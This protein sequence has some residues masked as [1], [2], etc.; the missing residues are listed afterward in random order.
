M[1]DIVLLEKRVYELIAAGEVIERPASVV[2]E[3]LENS[4]DA[5]AKSITVEIKNGGRT[6]IRVTDN[7]DGMSPGNISRA[8]LRHA[9]SKIRKKDDLEEIRTLGFRGEALASICAVSKVDT[10]SRT[11]DDELGIHYINEGGTEVLYEECGCPTG[12]TITIRELFYNVPA[13]LKF[14]KKDV[15]EGNAVANMVSKIALSRPDIS[16]KFIRDNKSELVTP[17]DGNLLS[18][19]YAVLGRAFSGSVIPV[20]YSM[21]GVGVKGY[22]T[23]PLMSKANRSF[24]NFFVNGR[25]VKSVTCMV[26]LEEAYRDSIMT[27]KFPGCVLTLTIDPS[28]IDVNVHPAK[29]EIRFSDEKPVYDAVYFAVKNALMT[30]DA[31]MEAQAEIKIE[32]PKMK[33]LTV[34]EIM[35][36]PAEPESQ[37][38]FALSSAERADGFRSSAKSSVVPTEIYIK[39]NDYKGPFGGVYS[40]R[41][42]FFEKSSGAEPEKGEDIKDESS[43]LK[44][45]S[46]KFSYKFITKPDINDE[47][48]PEALSEEPRTADITLVGEAFKTYIVAQRGDELYFIDKHAAHERY[49]FDRLRSGLTS[50]DVQ[51]ILTPIEVE[52]SYEAHAAIS[53]EFD[54]LCRLGFR[55]NVNDA[56]KITVF[57]VPI[58]LTDEDPVDL[59]T[60]IAD[61]LAE[62]KKSGGSD[63]YD[64]LLHSVACKAS[65]KAISLSSPEELL[66]LAEL[67]IDNK[68]RYCPHGRPT[69]IKFTK[70]ELEKL[71]KRIV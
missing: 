57:G 4:I 47:T 49:N 61:S 48:P 16:F 27:G 66:K 10:I 8:F 69:L 68:I 1:A 19:I 13:R 11:A 28:C 67:V 38:S 53:G 44:A 45:P 21:G 9:T 23:K 26:S 46:G 33:S 5:N 3:L 12:T 2:K 71:F 32:P 43:S 58:L 55:I 37:L 36:K 29:L 31:P 51:M 56:P 39:E 30:L 52:L 22:V 6:Y 17:G 63:I 60:E 65:I 42:P 7:G 41:T 59:L 15:S 25:Y 70:R 54:L 34:S 18:A 62:G 14:L 24:Q 40:P 64:E 35:H 50:V 20:D